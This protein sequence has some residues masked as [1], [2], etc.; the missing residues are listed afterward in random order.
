MGNSKFKSIIGYFAASLAGIL[1]GSWIILGLVHS[2]IIKGTVSGNGKQSSIISSNNTNQSTVEQTSSQSSSNISSIAKQLMPTVVGITATSSEG[3]G[4]GSGIILDSNGYILTNNHVANLQTTK[5]TVSLIDGRNVKGKAIWS[6]SNMDLSIIKIDTD[7]LTYAKLGDSSALQP[8]D[9]AVAIGNPLGL[10]YQ[11]SVTA[12]II[13]AINRSIT[14]AQE[15][16]YYYDLIQTD[17]SINEG[18]SGEPLINGNGEVIG[19]NTVK[20]S[21]SGSGYTQGA[22]VEG[23]GFAIPIN[24]VKPI[25]KS[26]ESTGKFVTPMIGISGIDKSS[27]SQ[28]DTSSSSGKNSGL[29]NSG[30]ASSKTLDKGVRVENVN[31]GSP[32]DKAGINVG[33]VILAVNGKTINTMLDLKAEIYSAGVGKSVT[34]SVQS[35]DGKQKDLKLTLVEM[36]QQ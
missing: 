19:V 16:M 7:N 24:I 22:S 23:M 15:G 36:T 6:D 12:G 3:E 34:L 33:D 4:V 28:T 25:L 1:I 10:T 26:I 27:I 30:S 17:A 35:A 31:S 20:V 21:S 9:T 2:G 5:I 32:A 8:G 18:N 11:R 29:N 13:S 14:N